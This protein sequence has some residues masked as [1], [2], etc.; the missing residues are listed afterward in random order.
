M[1]ALPALGP[2]PTAKPVIQT[3]RTR[4]G[5]KDFVVNRPN[6]IPL[7][8]KINGGDYVFFDIQP[9]EPGSVQSVS[10]VRC[11]GCGGHLW[12]CPDGGVCRFPLYSKL[13]DSTMRVWAHLDSSDGTMTEF[14]L[15]YAADQQ[16]CTANC[17][18]DAIHAAW[19]AENART[20][21]AVGAAKKVKFDALFKS[22]AK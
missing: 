9:D 21:P 14:M 16:V 15:Y 12:L 4:Q 10:V 8:E 20:C 5:Q 22:F 17:D 13:N 11:S 19:V 6:W 1:D 7:N 2:E 3:Q 18:Y